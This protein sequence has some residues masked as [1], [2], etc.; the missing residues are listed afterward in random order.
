MPYLSDL[1]SYIAALDDLGDI[2][3]I[4]RQVDGDLEPG[5][6]TRRSC[7]INSPAPLFENIEGAEPGFRI[8]GGPAALAS[9][10][11]MPYARV[12]LSLGLPPESAGPEIV[13]ALAAARD[14]PLTP[15]VLVDP[16]EAPCQQNVLRGE[17]AN[18]DLFPIPFAHGKDG[19]RYA[20]TWGTL[21]VK[22]P[23]GRWVNWAIARIMKVDGRRMVGLVVP[24]QHTGQ[25]WA[26][27]V[28]L[29]EPMPYAL[30]QGP[31]PAISCISGIPLPAEVDEVDYVGAL[32]GEPVELVKAIS[33]DLEVPAT[34]E[35]VIEGHVSITRDCM[36][37]PYG[38]YGGY[39][40]TGSSLQPT[41]HVETI[42]HRDEPIWPLVVAGRPAD[43]SH[44]I[45]AMGIAADALT[46]LRAAKL[47]VKT[48]WAPEGAA[49]HWLLVVVPADWRDELPGVSSEQ[50]AKQVGDVLFE[51]GAMLFIPKVFLVDDD[52][53]PTNL[54][55]VVWAISTRVH[56]TGRRA[57][58]E[59]QR[60]VRLPQ[61]YEEREYASGQGPKI[62]Y[63]LLLPAFGEGRDLHSSFEQG[64][65]EELKQHVLAHWPE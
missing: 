25:I 62:V 2:M 27:W 61:C 54:S 51:T 34:A 8:L 43:E 26:E 11:D 46:H 64:Y 22:T 48:V 28:K 32:V 47:A 60:I 50:F 57:V 18:L 55:D 6:I 4:T 45:W 19:G 65:P 36:E 16:S 56:P 63:D 37:G 35:I 44:T 21:I 53:D 10:P 12:A 40:G 41:F 31:A 59:D 7:E 1:R 20:N 3:H 58:F 13:E 33:V 42:T 29:G 39:L 17:D 23:D 30:V 52:I 49:V 5:A 9:R 15:P 24:S 38:E 14:L